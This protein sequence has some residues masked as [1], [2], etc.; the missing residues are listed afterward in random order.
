[1][2]FFELLEDFEVDSELSSSKS[3]RLTRL[4][5]NSKEK[6]MSL[7]MGNAPLPNPFSVLFH[8]G[9]QGQILVDAPRPKLAPVLLAFVGQRLQ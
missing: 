7:R 6:S 3:G 4:S 9:S 1:M 5:A 2:G 8:L